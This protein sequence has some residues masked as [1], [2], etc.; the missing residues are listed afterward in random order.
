MLNGGLD[1]LPGGAT[2]KQQVSDGHGVFQQ[3]PLHIAAMH[4]NVRI[5]RR[6][7][8][9][10]ASTDAHDSVRCIAVDKVHRR[11][12]AFITN[13]ISPIERRWW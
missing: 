12:E 5:M 6:L 4:G 10:G 8:K 7:L 9:L 3:A 13:S 11:S 1:G 2:K